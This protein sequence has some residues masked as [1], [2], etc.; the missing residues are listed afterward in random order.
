MTATDAPTMSPGVDTPTGLYL[1]LMKNCLTRY[2]FGQHYHRLDYPAGSLRRALYHPLCRLLA[3]WRLEIVQRMSDDARIRAE[4][5]DWPADAETMIGLRRLDNVQHCV[6]D[7]L[8]RGVP[9]DLI[10]TGVWRGGAVI[11]MRA[12]LKALG[13]RERTVWAADSFQG[14]PK[15]DA[16]RYP[17]DAGDPHWSF[18]PL[19]VTL[20]QVQENFRRYGL[21][22]E[23]VRFLPG[24]FKDTLPG[25]PIER[26]AVMRLDGDMYES[27][28][29]ALR[30]LYPKLSPGGYVIVDDY[31]WIPACKRAVEDYRAEQGITEEIV[32]IDR[33]GVYWQRRAPGQ[34]R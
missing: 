4:G 21:L 26:L 22:D 17:A 15:P 16:A 28:I 3:T 34:P 30:A 24:W 6:T 12:I 23:R 27:T 8:R 2:V 9:G 31:S 14:L 29:D 20:E 13:D 11:F 32:P 25:A 19:A 18:A 10:E 1:D 5:E 33:Q 7:V